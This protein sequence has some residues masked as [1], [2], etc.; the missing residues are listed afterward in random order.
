M[1]DRDRQQTEFGIAPDIQA[2]I[3]DSS[4]EDHIIETARQI[5]TK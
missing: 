5:L 2:S 1:Y 3:G 4:T